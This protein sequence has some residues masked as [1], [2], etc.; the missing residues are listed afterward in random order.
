VTQ[1]TLGLLRD[2]ETDS[3]VRHDLV[4]R[5]ETPYWQEKEQCEE[6]AVRRSVQ[7]H[8]RHVDTFCLPLVREVVRGM[9][10]I[11]H[12]PGVLGF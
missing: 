3:S 1:A 11:C 9:L 7:D 8:F 12:I 6:R 10:L 2:L 5:P 4:A